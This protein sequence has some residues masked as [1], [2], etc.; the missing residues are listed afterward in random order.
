M[1]LDVTS[2]YG[3]ASELCLITRLTSA[4]NIKASAGKLYYLIITNANASTR[5]CTLHNAITGTTSELV[6]FFT[7]G[8]TT[9][10]YN[11]DPPIPCDTGIRIGAIENSDTTITGGY[12]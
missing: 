11:F 5:H 9:K 2:T 1:G 6:K 7:S 10:V 4:G 8:E 3:R 12:V